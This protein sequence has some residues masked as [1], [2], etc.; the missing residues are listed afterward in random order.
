MRLLFGR[1]L[2][3]RTP[4]RILGA[5]QRA[6]LMWAM[7]A[8]SVALVAPA[9]GQSRNSDARKPGASSKS[10]PKPVKKPTAKSTPR[11]KP[12]PS[13]ASQ[14]APPQWPDATITTVAGAL[15]RLP[16]VPIRSLTSR[17]LALL[18]GLRFCEA[19]ARGDPA[20]ADWIEAVGYQPLPRDGDLPEHPDKPLSAAALRTQL[21]RVNASPIGGAPLG[22]FSIHDPRTIAPMFPAVA[23][24]MSPTRDYAIVIDPGPELSGW[25]DVRHC[26]VVRVR[27]LRATVMGGTLSWDGAP[28]PTHPPPGRSD[29]PTREVG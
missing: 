17:D 16:A 1:S 21:S 24:W 6:W 26:L 4:S 9:T 25:I 8:A 18:A 2:S 19:A 28:I 15:E 10:K 3:G 27:G 29:P 7:I 13:P 11:K 14:A 5:V 22:R 12:A 23:A 20:A